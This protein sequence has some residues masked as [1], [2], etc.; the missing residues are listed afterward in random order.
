MAVRAADDTL[1]DLGLDARPTRAVGDHRRD[2]E[3]FVAKVIELEHEDVR[4]AAIDARVRRQ[5][6]DRS[7]AIVLAFPRS[8]E[9]EAGPLSLR[10]LPVVPLVRI[11]KA[12]AAPSLEL[13][14]LGSFDR[15]ELIERF[16]FAAVC[17]GLHLRT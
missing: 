7:T 11:G 15:W 3:R 6:F 13:V 14:G 5:V 12:P 10:V 16:R 17:A 2:V 8:L 4:F 1:G 9:E